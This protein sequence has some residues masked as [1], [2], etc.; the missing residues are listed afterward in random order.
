MRAPKRWIIAI[1]RFVDDVAVEAVEKGIIAR[2]N[3]IVSPV[4][5]TSLASD[6]VTNIAGESEESRAKRKQLENQLDV[7]VQGLETCN[8]FMIRTL[9]GVTSAAVFDSGSGTF[10]P[11]VSL[12][13]P[14][15]ESGEV[16][17]NDGLEEVEASSNT[18]HIDGDLPTESEAVPD[19]ESEP[20]DMGYPSD[21]C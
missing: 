5:V 2:L 10:P 9:Q 1:E 20:V 14:C 4:E 17:T 13:S 21:S 6:V 8:R 7:L 12:N 19:E 11:D 3:D 18:A 15:R 16:I